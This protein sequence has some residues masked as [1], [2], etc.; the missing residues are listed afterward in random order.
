MSQEESEFYQK[1]VCSFILSRDVY[2]DPTS[3]FPMA[4]DQRKILRTCRRCGS[5]HDIDGPPASCTFHKSF[6]RVTIPAGQKGLVMGKGETRIKQIIKESKVFQLPDVPK[7]LPELWFQGGPTSVDKA[8]ALVGQTL[9]GKGSVVGAW[10]CCK[11]GSKAGGCTSELGHDSKTFYCVLDKPL[12]ATTQSMARPGK[13]FALDCEMVYTDRD[14]EVAMVTLLNF[15]GETCFESLVKPSARIKDYNTMY[16][17]MTREK[18]D[19]VRTTLKDVQKSL[20]RLISAGNVLL[21]HGID[22]DL[23]GLHL[24]HRQVTNTFF[25]EYHPIPGNSPN[26]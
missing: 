14:E 16:S 22:N 18:L 26:F 3:C 21:G 23:R 6:F 7:A 13:V 24:E 8:S 25:I 17:G 12:V 9:A 20:L 19:R 10:D 2:E 4:A 11:K 1:M 5:L 15:A